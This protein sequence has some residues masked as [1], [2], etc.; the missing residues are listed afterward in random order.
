VCPILVT[1]DT[2]GKLTLPL[3][4]IAE[5]EPLQGNK[6]YKKL[7]YLNKG[8]YGFVQLALD[9][10]TGEQV[11]PHSRYSVTC[12]RPKTQTN[13]AIYGIRNS[14]RRSSGLAP[15]ENYLQGMRLVLRRLKGTQH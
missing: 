10:Y 6:R 13:G 7:H 8:S 14:R 11:C 5:I 9:Q 1:Q 2:E 15:A 4:V 3:A 12:T